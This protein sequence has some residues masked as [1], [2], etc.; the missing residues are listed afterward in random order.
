MIRRYVLLYFICLTIPLFLGAS[1]WQSIR[2]AKLERE[3]ANLETAQV[4]WVE[5][6][7]QLIAGI[8]YYSAPA[9]VEYVA[10]HILGLSKVLPENVLQIRIEKRPGR[11]G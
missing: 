1:V 5:S 2:Y 7:V 10:R 4:K 3:L 9:R 11:D 6:N 8:A